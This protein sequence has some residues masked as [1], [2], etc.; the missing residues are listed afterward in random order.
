MY[1]K[2]TCLIQDLP[3]VGASR[4]ENQSSAS[5]PFLFLKHYIK[6]KENSWYIK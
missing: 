5:T 1:D 6:I 3:A 4:E 2:N